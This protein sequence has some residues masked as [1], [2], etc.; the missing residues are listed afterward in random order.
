MMTDDKDPCFQALV[1]DTNWIFPGMIEVV[2]IL[3]KM[4]HYK[5]IY[6]NGFFPSE[7][8]AQLSHYD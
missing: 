1:F 4:A 8:L 5:F 6:F 2:V 3:D 7:C